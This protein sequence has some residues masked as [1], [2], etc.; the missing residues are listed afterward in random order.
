MSKNCEEI[1]VLHEE[2]LSKGVGLLRKARIRLHLMMC[3]CCRDYTACSEKI[4]ETL[5]SQSSSTKSKCTEEEK[6][7]M[8]ARLIQD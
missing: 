6:G 7:R 4:E 1:Q 2:Q 3:K 5:K 8:K